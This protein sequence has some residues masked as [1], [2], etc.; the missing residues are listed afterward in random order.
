[1]AIAVVVED[2]VASV[3]VIPGTVIEDA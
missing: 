3:D 2:T 1:V